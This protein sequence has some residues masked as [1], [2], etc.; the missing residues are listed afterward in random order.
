MAST[1]VSAL[2]TGT[3]TRL[4]RPLRYSPTQRGQQCPGSVTL[5]QDPS[6]GHWA[7]P[8][9]LTESRQWQVVHRPTRHESPSPY[10]FPPCTQEELAGEGGGD[11]SAGEHRLCLLY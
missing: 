10:T 3:I 4:L 8:Q 1:V 6:W 5:G 11:R 2:P 7:P 9:K